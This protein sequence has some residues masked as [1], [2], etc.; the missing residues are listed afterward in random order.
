MEKSRLSL[1]LLPAALL[2]F[3]ACSPPPP[4]EWQEPL[5][6]MDFIY[7]HPGTFLMGTPLDE[8]ERRSDETLHEVQLTRGFYLGRYEVTQQEW[9]TVM[10]EN[11]SNFADCGPRCPVE[12]V[13]YFRIEE[14]IRQL[15]ESSPGS[16]FRLP[17]EAEWEYA[18]RA[19]TQTPFS[20]GATLST[21]DANF[22]GRYPYAGDPPGTYLKSTAP[23]G[24]YPP[25]PWGFY[26]MHGNV[27]EWCSDWYAPYPT[28]IARDPRGAEV[29][30]LHVIRGGSW[31]FGAD[32]ARSGSRY[33]HRPQDDGFSLGFRLVREF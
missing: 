23:A 1:T 4:R 21:A 16:R 18:C 32:S 7:V 27:W 17:T 5:T 8:P 9:A 20:T 26:D 15:Q 14:F 6:G 11:P 10:G 22:D 33:T 31:Y 2:L 29:G 19:G 12:K 24:S 30:E 3:G 28:G 25:N 13:S